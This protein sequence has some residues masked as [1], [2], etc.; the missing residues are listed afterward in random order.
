[1]FRAFGPDEILYLIE[2]SRWTVF[3]SL[4]AFV[5]G[6]VGGLVVAL[7]R[8]SESRLLRWIMMGFIR[9]IQ[10]TPLLMQLFVI[11]FG[12]NAFGYQISSWLAAVLGLSIHASAFLGEI[13]RGSIEAVPKGQAEAAKSLGLSYVQR[14]LLVTLPQAS[15]LSYAPTVGFAVQLIKATSLA[16]LIGVIEL[17]YASQ[18]INNATF[19]PFM[20]FGVTALIYFVLCWPLTLWSAHLE[21]KYARNAR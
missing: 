5:G 10:G 1:M 3:L 14:M 17:T 7:L 21:R 13:W 4:A 9:V 20:V 16:A 12:L 6:A 11:Y 19:R 18:I 2:A 15:V 8:V